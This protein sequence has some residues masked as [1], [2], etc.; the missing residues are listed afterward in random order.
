VREGFDLQHRLPDLQSIARGQVR[1]VQVVVD[2]ELIAGQFPS[3]LGPAITSTDDS[4]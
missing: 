1:R 3:I 4:S 2:V